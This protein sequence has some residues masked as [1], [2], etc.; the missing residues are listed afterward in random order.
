MKGQYLVMD[1]A[2]IHTPLQWAIKLRVE[3]IIVCIYQFTHP[4]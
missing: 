1:N 4:F 3:V 2:P